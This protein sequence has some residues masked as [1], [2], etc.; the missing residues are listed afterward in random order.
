M[1]ELSLIT[2]LKATQI[3]ILRQQLVKRSCLGS[4]S[5][6]VGHFLFVHSFLV[7]LLRSS[8]IG[9]WAVQGKRHCTRSYGTGITSP[10]DTQL[11]TVC[12][13]NWSSLAVNEK[14]AHT[15]SGLSRYQVHQ[16]GSWCEWSSGGASPFALLNS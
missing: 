15:K 11:L 4:P 12:D 6:G 9:K 7:I 16:R 13:E 3:E 10:S 14:S 1:H 5:A 8:S 2:A